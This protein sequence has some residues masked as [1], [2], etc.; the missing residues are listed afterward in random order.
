MFTIDQIN[1]AHTKVKSGADFPNYIQDLIKLGVTGFET[2]VADGH[3]VYLGK[4]RVEIQSEATY[5]VIKLADESDKDQ[6]QEDLKDHQQGK[7][8]YQTFCLDCAWSGIE[9][10][11]VDMSKMTCT[12]YDKAGNEMLV[13]AI[14]T[15][16]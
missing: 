11:V 8:N 7:T 13:E 1:E 14:S 4:D 12:Y 2:F 16:K 5:T 6:F 10:W 3:T 15:P 9:K